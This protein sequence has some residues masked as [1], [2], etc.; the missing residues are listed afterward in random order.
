MAWRRHVEPLQRIGFLARPRLVEIPGSVNE[1][2]T[3]LRDEIGT[4]FVTT[5]ADART[6]CGQKIHRPAPK[7]QLHAPYGLLGDTR[8][9]ATP[10]GVNGSDH[11]FQGINHENRHAVRSLYT[12]QLAWTVRDRRVA[13]P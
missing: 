4:Y 8:Q 7:L 1:L 9:G 5:R 12:E 11:T 13:L 3:E 10:T 2:R 6:E